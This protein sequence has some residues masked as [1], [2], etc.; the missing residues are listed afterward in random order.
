MWWP[1]PGGGQS[2]V[3][4]HNSWSLYKSFQPEEYTYS[5]LRTWHLHTTMSA[6]RSENKVA[7]IGRAPR[8]S[9]SL[10]FNLVVQL[11]RSTEEQETLFT[12]S[13]M[14]DHPLVISSRQHAREAE[15][16]R[17]WLNRGHA[18]QHEISVKLKLRN[19]LHRTG[20]TY[21]F[22]MKPQCFFSFLSGAA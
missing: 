18:H 1:K 11:S 21:K 14:R 20:G 4:H 9:R 8:A 22:I 5:S 13:S 3:G 12:R 7:D 19:Q 16:R 2:D 15:S 17:D 10:G 6:R